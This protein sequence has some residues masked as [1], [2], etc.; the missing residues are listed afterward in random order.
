MRVVEELSRLQ[1][2]VELQQAHLEKLLNER[3]LLRIS[4][5]TKRAAARQHTA[6]A[7]EE[8]R[9]LE[10]IIA[11]LTQQQQYQYHPLSSPLSSPSQGLRSSTV[12]AERMGACLNEME[13]YAEDLVVLR[14]RRQ[15][16]EGLLRRAVAMYPQY[17]I[18]SH[19]DKQR[20][21]DRMALARITRGL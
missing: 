20:E 2:T 3:Q 16:L 12:K 4:T 21:V 5:D 18:Q 13:K 6:Q 8:V 19:F 1:H 9:R 15:K 7:Q 14:E 10:S 11:T 17:D